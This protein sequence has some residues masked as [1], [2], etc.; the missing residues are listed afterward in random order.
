M[1]YK[2]DVISEVLITETIGYN[3]ITNWNHFNINELEIV[4]FC[5]SSFYVFHNFYTGQTSEK[6]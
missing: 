6:A 2:S 1:P 3:Q 5:F 4:F